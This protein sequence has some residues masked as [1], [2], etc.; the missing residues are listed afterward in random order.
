[1]TVRSENPGGFLEQAAGT[2][3]TGVA[4]CDRQTF[5]RGE[6]SDHRGIGRQ[7]EEDGAEAIGPAQAAMADRST[8]AKRSALF[9]IPA[10]DAPR[11]GVSLR[12][13]LFSSSAKLP[14]S[15]R[16][17]AAERLGNRAR[18]HPYSESS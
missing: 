5:R 7:Q 16:H 6:T 18:I 2:V 17:S 13:P 8:L 11:Y 15:T 10:S 4:T 12:S 14:C 1:M 3:G 9:L